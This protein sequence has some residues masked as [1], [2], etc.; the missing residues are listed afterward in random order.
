VHN[1]AS[2]LIKMCVQSAIEII[3]P[4]FV[5]SYNVVYEFK[6]IREKSEYVTCMHNIPD[7]ASRSYSDVY[8]YVII[9]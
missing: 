3:L 9:R 1:M 4:P 7:G 8:S 2:V 5:S 6:I